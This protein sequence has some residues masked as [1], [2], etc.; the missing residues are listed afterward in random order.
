MD[1]LTHVDLHASKEVQFNLYFLLLSCSCEE[2]S[3]LSTDC[4]YY[5]R[6]LVNDI[7]AKGGIRSTPS[8]EALKV[9]VDK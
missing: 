8:K 2:T 4:H 6:K 1:K 3:Q 9:F 5:E 7:T